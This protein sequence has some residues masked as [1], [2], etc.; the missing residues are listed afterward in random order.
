[1]NYSL[2]FRKK[3]ALYI[4]AFIHCERLLIEDNFK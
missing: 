3:E 1:M 4:C 2:F